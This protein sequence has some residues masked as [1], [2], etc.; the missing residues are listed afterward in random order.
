MKWL[1]RIKKPMGWISE[2]RTI[3]N[4]GVR[5]FERKEE[6]NEDRHLRRFYNCV[7]SLNSSTSN[8]IVA[9]LKQ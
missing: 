3:T 7:D 6:E 9:K 4:C 8:V 2:V 1:G 5:V